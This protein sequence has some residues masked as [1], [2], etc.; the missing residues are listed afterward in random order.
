MHRTGHDGTG[1]VPACCGLLGL[2]A[3]LSGRGGGLSGCGGRLRGRRARTTHDLPSP[4]APL[5]WALF[6][7]SVVFWGLGGRVYDVWSGLGWAFCSSPPW[8]KHSRRITGHRSLVYVQWLS[9]LVGGIE[10]KR[11]STR[12]MAYMSKKDRARRGGEGHRMQPQRSVFWVGDRVHYA[13][14]PCWSAMNDSIQR[15]DRDDS[16]EQTVASVMSPT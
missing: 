8:H 4:Q 15:A 7:G 13:Y 6:L 14:W 16:I 11:F 3:G 10:E 12:P 9:G 2:G 1:P 5:G